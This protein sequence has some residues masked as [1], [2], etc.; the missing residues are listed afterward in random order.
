MIQQQQQQQMNLPLEYNNDKTNWELESLTLICDSTC[1]QVVQRNLSIWFEIPSLHACDASVSFHHQPPFS[2][3][4]RWF[5][6]NIR[7][8]TFYDEWL[9][10]EL[11]PVDHG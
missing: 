2:S 5:R 6:G 9:K 11:L 8:T 3:S 4:P 7:S 1:Y 10:T